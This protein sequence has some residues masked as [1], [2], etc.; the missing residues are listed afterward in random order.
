MLGFW[1]LIKEKVVRL[2][3]KF[4]RSSQGSGVCGWVGDHD[5][6]SR[7]RSVRIFLLISFLISL[8]V[9]LISLKSF[10]FLFPF[11]AVVTLFLFFS[12]MTLKFYDLL[13]TGRIRTLWL[14]II[15][16]L[17]TILLVTVAYLSG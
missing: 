9:L 16:F 1:T 14:Y 15:I 6:L 2:F 13:K 5:R 10:V 12:W 3:R 4:C 7:L 17:V 11:V 8:Q